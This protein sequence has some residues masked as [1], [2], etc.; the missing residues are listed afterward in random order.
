MYITRKT[1]I[2]FYQNL[3][4]SVSKLNLNLNSYL[5]LELAEAPS[6]LTLGDFAFGF[7]PSLGKAVA[8]NDIG[9]TKIYIER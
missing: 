2:I 8:S 6:I 3:Q 1:F 4:F 9:L 7:S 5:D